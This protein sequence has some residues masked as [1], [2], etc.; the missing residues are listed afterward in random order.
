MFLQDFLYMRGY[1]DMTTGKPYM[2]PSQLERFLNQLD[3]IAK[4]RIE[5]RVKPLR[6]CRTASDQTE[7]LK[8]GM[9]TSEVITDAETQERTGKQF[10]FFRAR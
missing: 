10:L 2:K 1:V 9:R 3:G 5:Q 6:T 4:E 8:T 7:V